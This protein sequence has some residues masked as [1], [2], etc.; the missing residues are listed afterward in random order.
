MSLEAAEKAAER[1]SEQPAGEDEFDS[2]KATWPMRRRAFVEGYKAGRRD[3]DA[4]T[5]VLDGQPR[6]PAE[7]LERLRH[8]VEALKQ[9]TA[10]L[11]LVATRHDERLATLETLLRVPARKQQ[12]EVYD[13][14]EAVPER[15]SGRDYHAQLRCMNDGDLQVEVD[16][17]LSAVLD[18]FEGGFGPGEI[19]TKLL[20]AELRRRRDLH[21]AG[22]TTGIGESYREA[23]NEAFREGRRR[24]RESLM[25]Y[26][27][28]VAPLPKEGA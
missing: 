4:Q 15:E 1:F 11:D 25:R 24:E 5:V 13:P 10:R 18:E 26:L 19:K 7:S 12:V 16:A 20:L 14:G 9:T 23:I 27:E 17:T 21:P 6:D 28:H 8:Q 22:V 2:L 3:A